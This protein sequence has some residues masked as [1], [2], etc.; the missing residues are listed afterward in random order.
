MTHVAVNGLVKIFHPPQVLAVFLGHLFVE[1]IVNE[2]VSARKGRIKQ[3]MIFYFV[4]MIFEQKNICL[5]EQKLFSLPIL[6]Y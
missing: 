5:Q 2:E 1:T 4:N 6:R 3:F